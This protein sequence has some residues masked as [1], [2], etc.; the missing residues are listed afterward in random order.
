M[1]KSI[2]ESAHGLCCIIFGA[3]VKKGGVPS[4]T[5]RRR[6]DG[7]FAIGGT[8][9]RYFVTGGIGE[10]PPSEA[11]VM[12]DLLSVHGVPRVQII[13]DADA[14]DTLT[15]AVNCARLI[16]A[17]YDCT[18]VVACSNRYH[19]PR[20][21]MLLR[22]LGVAAITMPM[23]KDRPY[24]S[25]MK[26][27]YFYLREMIAYPYDLIIVTLSRHFIHNRSEKEKL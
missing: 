19:M 23:P 5:L 14:T 25:Y 2:D 13:I 21:R 20:C 7:A 16:A 12:A 1:A 17:G 10:F 22:C 11:E 9:A 15:S 27:A 8:T 26:L 3:A 24:V 6:V 18:Q 4:G